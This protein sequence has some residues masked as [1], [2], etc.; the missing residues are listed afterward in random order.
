MKV[1]HADYPNLEAAHLHRQHNLAQM[2]VAEYKTFDSIRQIQVYVEFYMKAQEVYL[3]ASKKKF[4]QNFSR[5]I[6]QHYHTAACKK[7]AFYAG[8]A[9]GAESR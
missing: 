3:C 4:P 1:C 5:R 2:Y 7:Y 8:K 9:N 6:I